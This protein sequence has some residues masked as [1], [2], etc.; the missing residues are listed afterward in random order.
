MLGGLEAAIRKLR[1]TSKNKVLFHIADAPHHGSRF[2]SLGKE[3]DH[4]FDKQPRGLS[5]EYLMK[6][7]RRLNISMG[8]YARF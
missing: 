1:W 6:E 3:A 7:I 8:K 2:H 4:Y 5:I